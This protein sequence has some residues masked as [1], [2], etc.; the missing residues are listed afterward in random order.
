MSWIASAPPNIHL[1]EVKSQIDQLVL[2][3]K[4]LGA[5]V[6][7]QRLVFVYQHYDRIAPDAAFQCLNVNA[8][9][10]EV[11]EALARK[12]RIF[13]LQALRNCLGLAPLI[14]TWF[15]LFQAISAYQIDLQHYPKDAYE[16][17]LKLWQTGFHGTTTLIFTVVALFDIV[18]LLS[19]VLVMLLVTV[20]EGRARNNAT[21]FVQEYQLV[22][23][24]LLQVVSSQGI[25]PIASNA[26]VY[27]VTAAI[28]QVIDRAVTESQQIAEVATTYLQTLAQQSQ[29]S[30]DK[31]IQSMQEFILQMTQSNV[32]TIAQAFAQAQIP[33]QQIVQASQDAIAA[34]NKRVEDLFTTQVMPTMEAFNI[35]ITELQQQ[36]NHLMG[37]GKQLAT[38]STSLTTNADKYT[39]LSQDLVTHIE[40]FGR[41]IDTLSAVQKDM[42]TQTAS[43]AA[44]IGSIEASFR[45]TAGSMETATKSVE[46]VSTNMTSQIGAMTHLVTRAAETLKLVEQYMGVTSNHLIQTNEQLLRIT[47]ELHDV[48]DALAGIKIV[49]GGVVGWAIER[50]HN[51]RHSL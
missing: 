40:A 42:V 3:A 10:D 35:N 32:Q 27:R 25:F 12:Y 7:I 13:L 16:P 41:Q 4:A 1:K 21:D 28:R 31:M 33:V 22:I 39:T 9:H 26:D 8:F 50:W 6:E 38:V 24:G 49:D 5:P 44:R 43:L 29:L 48:T 51:R 2:R 23:E 18:F 37:V 36:S 17:L 45:A 11:E 34:S 47:Q 46:T 20:L 14:L 15:A 30:L 19:Y